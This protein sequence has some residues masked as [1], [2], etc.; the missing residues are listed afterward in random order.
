LLL[1]LKLP[2]APKD[3]LS[4]QP[5]YSHSV[6][7]ALQQRVYGDQRCEWLCGRLPGPESHPLALY[8]PRAYKPLALEEIFAATERIKFLI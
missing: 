5:G 6:C 4:E 1:A 3:V 2:I 8:A 7:A